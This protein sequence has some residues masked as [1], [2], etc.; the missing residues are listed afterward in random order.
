M[1]IKIKLKDIIAL[2]GVEETCIYHTRYYIQAYLFLG[3]VKSN[4]SLLWL[5]MLV[6]IHLFIYF[7]HVYLYC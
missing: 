4:Y 2:Y 5:S 6:F 3:D 7:D 1:S